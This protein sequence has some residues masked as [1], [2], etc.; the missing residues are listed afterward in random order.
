MKARAQQSQRY[1]REQFT[2]SKSPNAHAVDR[3]VA[4]RVLSFL[5]NPEIRLRLWNGSEFQATGETTSPLLQFND[6]RALYGALK[7]PELRFGDLYSEGRIE[8]EGDLP[9]LLERVYHGIQRRGD[10]SNLRRWADR[11]TRRIKRNTLNRAAENIH[12]H[13]DIGNNFYRLW[14]DSGYMQY[15]CAYYPDPSM[16]LEQA[17]QAK[18]HHVCRKLQLRPGDTVVEAGCGWGGLA[19]FMAEH[20]GV[21]VRAYNISREQ[22]AYATETAQQQ[23]LSD[24]V[25]YV[26]DDY[27]NITGQYDVFV[28][29][30]ML[31]HVGVEQ[32]PELG[33]VIGRCLKNP[34]RG[35]I[36]SIGRNRP[37]PLNAWIER[38]IFPGAYPPTL[39][40]A[41]DI[42]EPNGLSVLDVEN[43]RQPYALTLRE[44]LHNFNEHEAQVAAMH[45]DRFVRA[46]RLYLAGS[47]AAFSVGELQLFQWVF[48]QAGNN[49]IPWSRTHQYSPPGTAGAAG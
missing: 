39:R 4:G 10:P 42:F 20:Y 32:Y 22:V 38:R 46:W 17:Q 6:R 44:W 15:T 37:K 18:L 48:T 11:L 45:D 14:L 41:A 36:H 5:G 19:R 9:D 16:S 27:R 28:S 1:R 40:E 13:Y 24:R 26:L 2:P 49:A 35:L 21:A 25:E 7:S 29:V 33:R 31:E 3:L 23:G 47:Q 12:H 30:G 43:L 8:I 34:G